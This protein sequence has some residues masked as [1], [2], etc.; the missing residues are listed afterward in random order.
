MASIGVGIDIGVDPDSDSNPDPELRATCILSLTR[1][2]MAKKGTRT[3]VIALETRR[4]D[5]LM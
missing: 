2:V 4:I 5:R 3:S 1:L